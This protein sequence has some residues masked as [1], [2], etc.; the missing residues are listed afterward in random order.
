VSRRVG[1][2][3]RTVIV[4]A[5]SALSDGVDSASTSSERTIVEPARFSVTEYTADVVITCV[6]G[7]ITANGSSATR[8]I[9]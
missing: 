5:L 8:R 4:V 1:V 6:V 2:P 7:T 3:G 9:C